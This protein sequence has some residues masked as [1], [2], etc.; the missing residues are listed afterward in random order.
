MTVSARVLGF[1]IP[2]TKYSFFLTGGTFIVPIAFFSQDIITEVFGYH[3]AKQT[4]YLTMLIVSC[5]VGYI[6]V[7]TILP[8]PIGNITCDAYN[9]IGTSLPRHL[10]AFL[11]SFF[12]GSMSNNIVLIKLKKALKGRHLAFRFI[13]S[14]AIGE[15]ILQ[16]VGT[17]IAWFGN[18]HFKHE[19][20]PFIIISLSYKILF[21]IL[22]TPLNILICNKLKQENNQ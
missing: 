4:L 2:L 3:K 18:M 22:M 1:S 19:I 16:F 10:L 17:T 8:C 12:I 14:T 9:I 13:L 5:F 20:L 21:E 6:Y 15:L 7:L 11:T